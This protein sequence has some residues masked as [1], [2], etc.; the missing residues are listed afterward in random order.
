[1]API[2]LN[3][4]QNA[5][6]SDRVSLSVRR[7]EISA[8]LASSAL[9]LSSAHVA[10]ESGGLRPEAANLGLVEEQFVDSSFRLIC[11]EEID[12][13]RWK[14]FAENGG[15]SK[16]FKKGSIRAVCLRTP[17]APVE[18]RIDKVETQEMRPLELL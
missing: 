12:G 13:R 15:G 10:A 5:A 11:C 8:D 9:P 1:M 4:P 3:R 7:S 6:S 18:V 17:Q 14:Y 2:K 16:R